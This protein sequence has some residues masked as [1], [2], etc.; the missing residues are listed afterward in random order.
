MSLHDLPSHGQVLSWGK[1]AAERVLATFLQSALP[2]VALT[3]VLSLDMW[4]GAA[5]AGSAAVLS[6]VK[7]FIAQFTG[8]TDSASM[9]G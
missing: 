1:D 9:I 6:L 7:S 8:R 5:L 2:A 3:E 4:K